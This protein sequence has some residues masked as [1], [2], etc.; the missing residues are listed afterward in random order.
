M[1]IIASVCELCQAKVNDFFGWFSVD[2]CI[3]ALVTRGQIIAAAPSV[4][5]YVIFGNKHT[6]S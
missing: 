6:L 5:R 1:Y 2:A 4:V 3:D